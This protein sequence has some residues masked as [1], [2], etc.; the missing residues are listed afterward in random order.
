MNTEVSE[1]M[2]MIL[3]DEKIRKFTSNFFLMIAILGS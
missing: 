3:L 1:I 2:M